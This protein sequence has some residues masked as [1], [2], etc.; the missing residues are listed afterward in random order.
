MPLAD[1]ELAGE[2]DNQRWSDRAAELFA[3]VAKLALG[4][5]EV[6]LVSARGNDVPVS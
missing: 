5:L 3:P 6:P 1:A 2:C 4:E